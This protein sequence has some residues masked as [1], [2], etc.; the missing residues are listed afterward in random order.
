MKKKSLSKEDKRDRLLL[1]GV[2]EDFV[3]DVDEHNKTREPLEDD[4]EYT[5]ENLIKWLRFN[6]LY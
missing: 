6:I 3:N 5:L 1:M 4:V 2:L